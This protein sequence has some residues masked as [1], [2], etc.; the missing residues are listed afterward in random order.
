[1]GTEVHCV[2]DGRQPP[3]F[4]HPQHAQHGFAVMNADADAKVRLELGQ[5][6]RLH[7]FHFGQHRPRGAHGIEGGVGFAVHAEERHDAIADEVVNLA[8]VLDDHRADAVEVTVEDS[9]ITNR[10]TVTSPFSVVWHAKRTRG[11]KLR[12]AAIFCSLSLRGRQYCKPSKTSTRQVEQRALPPQTWV[13]GI[14]FWS[15]VCRIEMAG[16]VSTVFSLR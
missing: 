3:P 8:A 2:A 14:P 4:A 13:C 15:D 10:R 11:L 9:S 5:E 16:S 12:R 6:I 7:P 1:M